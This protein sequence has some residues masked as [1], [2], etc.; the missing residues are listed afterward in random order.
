MKALINANVYD[1]Y[2]YRPNG[3]VLF[4]S[5]IREVGEMSGFPGA[6]QVFDCKNTLV[7]PGLINGHAH[8]YSA[9]VRGINL[10][11]SPGG[12][13]ELL[14]QL[15]WKFDQAIDLDV[16]YVSAKVHGIEHLKAGVTTII[17]HHA[18]GAAI[19]GTLE[20]LKRAICDELGMRGI[21]CFETSDRFNVDECIAENMEFIR[22]AKS[23]SC[24]GLFGMHA[25]M[26]LSDRTLMKIRDAIGDIPVHVH[27]AESLE[28]E[29]KCM[30]Q[31]GKRVVEQFLE[32]DLLNR[33]SLLAHCVHINET[34][35]DI[36]AEQG[37][38]VAINPG[39]NMNNGVGL[40]DYSLFKTRQIPVIL[41]N[42][43][44]G[45]QIA[46]DYQTLLYAMHH[47]SKSA[48]QF[49]YS[50]LLACI[51]SVYNYVSTLLE[52]PIGRLE[53]GYA[54]DMLSVPYL[55]PTPMSES[56]IFCHIVNGVFEGFHAREVWC[57]GKLR[58][59]NFKSCFD[60]TEIYAAARESAKK[61]WR[62]I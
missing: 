38:V 53:S 23:S 12:F 8:N 46:R 54:A 36:I 52:V 47:R 26:S 41:G 28:D 27:V 29:T 7:L 34:E 14:D 33:N 31:Y 55:V 24:S 56:N 2:N 15:W 45:V 16:T 40:P 9:L 42:D 57:Q 6:Q 37:C 17:D 60:E 50:D 43:S 25:S 35:A 48:W 19:R 5:V 10:P 21:F 59:E 49:S 30:A 62:R 22:E 18:S 20:E 58:V 39:S 11:F 3:Y 1:Y 32:F 44:L 4:D 61:L 51:R 13:Q